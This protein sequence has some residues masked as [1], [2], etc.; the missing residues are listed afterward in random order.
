MRLKYNVFFSV[1]F[2][3]LGL[4][5]FLYYSL[6][7]LCASIALPTTNYIVLAC[8]IYFIAHLLRAARLGML[9]KAQQM[10]KLLSLHF[11]TAACSAIIPLKLGELVRIN[12][13][14][15]W[16]ENYCKGILIVWIERI[17][18]VIVLSILALGFLLTGGI[19]AMEGMW[20]LITIMFAFALLSVV[21]LLLIPEQLEAL[22]YHILRSYSGRKAVKILKITEAIGGILERVKPIISNKILTLSALT[23]LIWLSELGAMMLFLEHSNFILIAKNLLSQF[24][25]QLTE[26]PK[27][28]GMVINVDS[29]KNQLLIVCGMISVLFYSYITY[30]KYKG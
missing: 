9:L 5:L 22:N 3:V 28:I 23:L 25:F 2:S 26:S 6:N 20:G 30:Q 10:R 16:E 12:E 24:A 1:A 11:Y 8:I 18:D 21:L 15:R 14:S 13:V 4:S 7:S 19:D 17:F 27:T 29:M